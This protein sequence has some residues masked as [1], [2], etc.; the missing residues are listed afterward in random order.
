MTPG[1]LPPLSPSSS[2]HAASPTDV[3]ATIQKAH[4][5][6]KSGIWAN[7]PRHQ[8]ADVL[9][10]AAQ[11]LTAALPDL[12]ALEV[13]QTGRCAREMGAQVPSLVRWFAY[14]AAL[15]RTEG[16]NDGRGEQSR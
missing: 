5:A 10:R 4:S 8:R 11:L 13:Q 16:E 3:E 14:Y 1:P 6:F 15:L 7:A 12:I 2:C 9:D